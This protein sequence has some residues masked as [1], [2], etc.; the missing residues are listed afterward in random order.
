MGSAASLELFEAGLIPGPA[1]WIKDLAS[2]LLRHRL[3][4]WLRSDPWPWSSICPGAAKRGEKKNSQPARANQ[5]G[6]Y[7]DGSSCFG[8]AVK[9]PTSIHEDSGSLTGLAQWVAMSCDAGRRWGLD[10]AWLWL[11]LWHRRQLQLPLDPYPG[12]FHMWVW[13]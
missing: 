7:F 12:N 1:Q 9:N 11:W 8:S 10:L 2:P 13:P 5:N 3:Q 6:C 4:L